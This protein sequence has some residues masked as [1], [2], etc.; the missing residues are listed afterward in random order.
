[1]ISQNSNCSRLSSVT[2]LTLLLGVIIACGSTGAPTNRALENLLDAST[3]KQFNDQFINHGSI[4]AEEL[5]A[6][7]EA[8]SSRTDYRRRNAAKLLRTTVKG[9]AV[10]LEHRAVLETKYVDVWAIVADDV[11]Q[12]EPDMAGRRPDMIKA[13]LD[14]SDTYTLAVGLR[15]AVLSNYPGVHELARKYLDHKDAKVRAAAVSGLTAADV[16]ELLPKLNDMVANERDEDTFILLAKSLIRT[17]DPAAA[18]IVVKSLERQKKTGDNLYVHFFND[19]ALFTPP[20]PIV[21]KF[22]FSLARGKSKMRDEGFSVFSR[23]VWSLKR[24]PLPEFVRMCIDEIQQGNLSTDPRRRPE[25]RSEQ[26]SCEEMLSFMNDGKNPI[27]DFEGRVRGK[28]A[29]AFAGKWLSD[30]PDSTKSSTS[31]SPKPATN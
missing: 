28:D 8:T 17:N 20:D 3:P 19:L 14:D 7:F 1:M 12:N 5:P 10:E 18:D 21:T 25:A 29:V 23:W 16:R 26:N 2:A 27:G 31:N 4:R 22:L 30:H 15:A 6:I 24:E 11:L 13:A 9:N